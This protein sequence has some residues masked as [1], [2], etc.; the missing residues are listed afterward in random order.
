MTPAILSSKWHHRYHEHVWRRNPTALSR[1][2]TKEVQELFTLVPCLFLE[3]PAAVCPFS[4]FSCYLQET[5]EDISLL[6]ELSHIDTSMPDGLLMSWNCF[7]DFAVGHW[8]CC[9]ATK[10][11]FAGDIGTIEVSLID[12]IKPTICLP[13]ICVQ[14]VVLTNNLCLQMFDSNV[15]ADKLMRFK[16]GK[17]KVIKVS[18]LQ[19]IS[20]HCAC[21][22]APF[23]AHTLASC[24]TKFGARGGAK[25]SG[26]L[27]STRMFVIHK[28]FSQN[29]ITG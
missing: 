11:G 6:L 2:K 1:S 15:S 29:L 28:A 14:D 25:S 16:L 12:S 3:Q 8:F 9:C 22:Y 24:F 19:S 20:M 10:P 23:I 21:H 7:L 17:G 27:S 5:T 26:I 18:M 4:R 13:V